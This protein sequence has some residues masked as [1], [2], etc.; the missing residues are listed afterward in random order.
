MLRSQQ[1]NTSRSS[2]QS[3]S[4]Q[5]SYAFENR[6]KQEGKRNIGARFQAERFSDLESMSIRVYGRVLLLGVILKICIGTSAKTEKDVIGVSGREGGPGYS[7]R[8]DGMR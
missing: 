6:T 2:E 3:I 4:T 5:P 8:N 7:V 1:S